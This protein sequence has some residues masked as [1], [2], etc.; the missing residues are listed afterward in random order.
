[1]MTAR[2]GPSGKKM[3][4][5]VA[6]FDT[7]NPATPDSA[8]CT[9]EICPTKP[10]ITTSESRITVPIIVLMSACRKSNGRTISATT[11]MTDMTIAGCVSRSGRGTNGRRCS[12]SSPR[13]GRLA[14]R[15]NSASTMTRKTK[16]SF[17]PG[18][19]APSAFGNQLS[20]WK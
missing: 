1:M 14:P 9:T 6:N 8:S 18:I 10:V 12:T 17:M 2:I 3:S 19:A 5:S 4:A 13:P 11:Q 15:R 16:R 7:A 20:V